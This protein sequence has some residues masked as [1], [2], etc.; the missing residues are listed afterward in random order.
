MC[1]PFQKG[2]YLNLENFKRVNLKRN[3]IGRHQKG[4]RLNLRIE[5]DKN[6]DFWDKSFEKFACDSQYHYNL[7]HVLCTPCLNDCKE[8]FSI[9]IYKKI[10][11]FK[12]SPRKCVPKIRVSHPILN[13]SFITHDFPQSLLLIISVTN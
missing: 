11:I 12:I 6:G 13:T 10:I 1:S 8:C 4:E 7:G 3:W 9:D 5:K 2:G